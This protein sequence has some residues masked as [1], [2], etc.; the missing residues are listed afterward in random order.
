M[1]IGN[2]KAAAGTRSW[3]RQCRASGTCTSSGRGSPRC[4]GHWR[5]TAIR[6]LSSPSVRPASQPKCSPEH[7]RDRKGAA[8]RQPEAVERRGNK[9]SGPRGAEGRLWS[10]CAESFSK[11]GLR[12]PLD[13][14]PS[15]YPGRRFAW[16]IATI[17]IVAI[18]SNATC[19]A[20]TNSIP[21]PGR[22][23]SYQS[24]AS[25]SSS[26]A[27][28]PTM[29]RRFTAPSAESRAGREPRTTRSPASHRCARPAPDVRAQRARPRPTL[30]P[31]ALPRWRAA[32]RPDAG[33]VLP[34][35]PCGGK[36]IAGGVGHDLLRLAQRAEAGGP[37]TAKPA[38]CARTRERA[39]SAVAS[40]ALAH[41]RGS[42]PRC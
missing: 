18:A 42:G 25:P 4:I 35:G 16:A 11:K 17:R 6:R 26:S 9:K 30:Y 3:R 21:G 1:R 23:P 8:K 10:S 34:V 14:R 37:S 19:T 38:S 2:A 5:R 28:S 32:R 27:S 41:A 40:L 7:N 15:Q 29:S 24:E 33:A 36:E 39:G 12:A 22:F 13:H 20:S 31:R